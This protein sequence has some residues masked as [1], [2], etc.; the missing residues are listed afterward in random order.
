[1][2]VIDNEALIDMTDVS[3]EAVVEV[4]DKVTVVEDQPFVEGGAEKKGVVKVVKLV[5]DAVKLIAD[6]V[7]DVIVVVIVVSR[8][9]RSSGHHQHHHHSGSCRKDR[10][11]V[12]YNATSLSL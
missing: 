12:A 10:L 4:A 8:H 2:V 6:P 11:G 9:S 3:Y 7:I 5:V 1:V